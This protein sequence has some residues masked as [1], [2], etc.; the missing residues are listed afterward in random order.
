MKTSHGFSLVLAAVALAACAAGDGASHEDDNGRVSEPSL[1]STLPTISPTIPFP[2]IYIPCVTISR[3]SVIGEVDDTWLAPG[4]PTVNFADNERLSATGLGVSGGAFNIRSLI[5]FDIH[6]NAIPAGASITTAEVVLTPIEP[7]DPGILD[8]S[9]VNYDWTESLITFK[10]APTVNAYSPFFR[11]VPFN[12]LDKVR[13]D[14]TQQVT[15]WVSGKTPNHGLALSAGGA[16]IDL[17]GFHFGAGSSES[18]RKPYLS[19]CWDDSPCSGKANGAA[20]NDPDHCTVNGIC[21]AGS[22]VGSPAP[23]NTV[24]RPA[25][26]KCDA[27]E[28]CDGVKMACPTAQIA[29][30]GTTCRAV[31]GPCDVAE[32]CNGANVQCPADTFVAANTA[33]RGAAGP[34]DVAEVCTGAAAAC[35]ADA[36]KPANTACGDDG[37][38]CTAD[39]CDGIDDTCQHPAGNAGTQCRAS[40]GGCD[41]AETCNGSS[42]ACPPDGFHAAGTQCRG[43]AGP[44]DVAEACT[45]GSAQCP[46]DAFLPASTLCRA[47]V[48]VCD[49][50][51]YCPGNGA[52]CADHTQPAGSSCGAQST[53]QGNSC[54]AIPCGHAY[55]ACCQETTCYPNGNQAVTCTN[56]GTA[57]NKCANCGG[58]GQICCFG[59]YGCEGSM[60]CTDQFGG[61]YKCTQLLVDRASQIGSRGAATPMAAFLIS[62]QVI[63]RFPSSKASGGMSICVSA[64]RSF[65]RRVRAGLRRS[66]KG[67]PI[68]RSMF[69][70]A[71]LAALTLTSTVSV[72]QLAFADPADS[73]Q[74]GV[75]FQIDAHALTSIVTQK[76]ESEQFCFDSFACPVGGGMCTIDHLDFPKEA[77]L[78]HASAPVAIKVSP[79]I[80]VNANPLQIALPFVANIKTMDCVGD[81]ACAPDKYLA[82]P[83][84]TAVF[85]VTVS[86][87]KICAAFDSLEPALPGTAGL[88]AQLQASIG[89]QCVPVDLRPLKPLLGSHAVTGGGITANPALDRLAVRFEF[90]NDTASTQGQWQ[91]FLQQGLIGPSTVGKGWSLL[92]GQ[93]LLR[94]A[95]MD[96]LVQG[97]SQSSSKL[98]IDPSDDQTAT[99]T[100]FPPT[101]TVS[102]GAQADTGVCPNKI[103]VN[104][105]TSTIPFSLDAGGNIV[106]DGTVD[107]NVVDSDVLWC[108][109]LLGGFVFAPITVPIA[110]AIAAGYDPSYGVPDCQTPDSHHFDCTYPVTLPALQLGGSGPAGFM[111]ANDLRGDPAGLV[112]SGDVILPK[113]PGAPWVSAEL[114]GMPFGV[115]GDCNDLHIGY[116][117]DLLVNGWAKM[118]A[119][120]VVEH[121]PDNV[122]VLTEKDTSTQELT[123]WYDVRLYDTPT[124]WSKPYAPQITLRTSAGSFTYT[125]PKPVEYTGDMLWVE[126]QRIE[127][128]VSCMKLE[129]GFLGDPGRFDPRW[130]VDPPTDWGILVSSLD[131]KVGA[132]KGLGTIR[133]ITVDMPSLGALR[134]SLGKEFSLARQPVTVTAEVVVAGLKGQTPTAVKMSA[135]GYATLTGTSLGK[136]GVVEMHLAQ[137][138]SLTFGGT[139]KSLLPGGA[140]LSG[141]VTLGAGTVDLFGVPPKAT[142]AL[143]LLAHKKQP[144]AKTPRTPGEGL[145]SSAVLAP[146][147][148]VFFPS[149]YVA[150]DA[151]SPPSDREPARMTLPYTVHARDP[152]SRARRG[153]LMTA[154]GPVETPAF[155]AVGTRASVTGISPEELTEIGA[156]MI[157]GNTYHLML[158][159]GPELFRRVGGI[160]KFMAW[161]GPVLTD[162]GGYQIFSL[163]GA[164]T[165]TEEGASFRSYIDQRIHMLSPERSIEMQTAIGCDVMMVLDECVDSTS[166][167]DRTRLAMER[168]HRWALRSLAARTNPAQGL[169]AIVQG[170]LVPELRRESASFLTQ[171]DFDG[172]AVGGLAVGDARHE[173]ED[174]TRLTADLLPADRPRYLMGVGTPPDLLEA[175][176]AGID[177][178]DCILPTSM[179]F[180]ATAFTSTGRVKITRS[181][182][183][184]A[185]VPLDAECTCYACRTFSRSYLHHLYKAR[186]PLVTRLVAKHNLHHYLA[187]MAEAR[188][189]IE[190]GTYA[191]FA[192]A[193]LDR[194][195]RHEHSEKRMGARDLRSVRE[196]N[197]RAC[198]THDHELHSWSSHRRF[199]GFFAVDRGMR[200]Q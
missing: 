67:I 104:P 47:S 60:S 152:G 42:T 6:P 159:P 125:G 200:W 98:S 19:I 141:S 55:Q 163:P 86:G 99:W 143:K 100:P 25:S 36:K 145:K 189:A 26:N 114:D 33:C 35:P 193:K 175:I 43:S 128:E 117:G 4:Y 127:D 95:L 119:P 90:D 186:E 82:S 83:Q 70:R 38:P 116:E 81:P 23:A 120:P 69:P 165:M 1:V 75:E 5:R 88:V 27:A 94:S 41:V 136:A 134:G 113:P 164:R 124:F 199:V 13:F 73:L 111:K 64:G 122:Y 28:V 169:F 50:A 185:D 184:N 155:M 195:D 156:G 20:C 14:V 2:P 53:C 173:R 76:A 96:R 196:L 44:C 147:R 106:T 188:A 84:L 107:W 93:S 29:P 12:G 151:D 132:Q 57:F 71:A 51:D 34:C 66:S 62:D 74:H 30:I 101:V 18:T 137:P 78:R 172:F 198:R 103:G 146:W 129:T 167:R 112:L 161:P 72:S 149:C 142:T 52:S 61:G 192:A 102:L 49:V 182:Y 180:Q 56:P 131:P 91:Q 148:L 89:T 85:D 16:A 46:G 54:V 166:D 58:S 194:I 174:V 153:T 110:G 40:A 22:C 11:A 115:H 17:Q 154:H 8:V 160:H 59:T 105:I 80:T 150:A 118:C 170:G 97:I 168:T 63:I 135:T 158:R 183:L 77:S 79:E 191:A 176:G 21:Q 45:G 24:C 108:G 177:M 9:L 31:A 197:W 15:D 87:T 92:V 39:H 133:S 157:L 140:K 109:V 181:A 48:G 3:G 7:N 171:H 10:T 123:K 130:N 190:A 37:N 32:T 162:S 65:E 138:L 139:S 121:D 179:A 178:F 68:M 144:T 187:L 126:V